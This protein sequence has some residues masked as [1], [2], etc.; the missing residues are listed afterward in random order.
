M[1]PADREQALAKKKPAARKVIEERLKEFDALSP[2]QRRARLRLM[3]LQEQLLP[4][5][6]APASNRGQLLVFVSKED[7]PLIEQR[8][9]SWDKFSPEV[10]RLVLENEMVM[11]YFLTGQA[12][13]IAGLTTNASKLPPAAGTN[14]LA[15]IKKWRELTPDQQRQAYD[16]FNDLFGLP[17]KERDKVVGSLQSQTPVDHATVENFV[18]E[19]QKLPPAEREKRMLAFQKFSS[20][21]AEQRA[22]FLENAGRWQAM[23][24]ADREAFR[25]M[26]KDIPPPALPTAGSK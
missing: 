7:Q 14:M 4:L 15:Q 11:R 24:E 23:S 12:T 10:Q 13:T 5:L 26:L 22:R 9:R 6:Q 16:A 3:Q 20:M 21:T 25:T 17:E 18:K 2:D 8:L 19:F 1:T